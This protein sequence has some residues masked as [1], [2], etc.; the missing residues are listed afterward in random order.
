M[1]PI[2]NLTTERDI[3]TNTNEAHKG[4]DLEVE[5]CENEY[6]DSQIL[7]LLKEM[8]LHQ[9]RTLTFQPHYSVRAMRVP[10]GWIYT[11][12]HDVSSREPRVIT[13]VFVPEVLN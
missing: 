3:M 13:Q 12:S 2:I 7:E 11:T 4:E 1:V 6:E 8:P 9:S 5:S 10:N